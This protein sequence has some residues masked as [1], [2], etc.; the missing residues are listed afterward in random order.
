MRVIA[1][2]LSWTAT[3]HQRYTGLIGQFFLRPAIGIEGMC[4][5]L[6]DE[7]DIAILIRIIDAIV[8]MSTLPFLN[9][10]FCCVRH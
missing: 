4:L 3:E 6:S 8:L 2:Y 10:A 5:P 9:A 1:A 7:D